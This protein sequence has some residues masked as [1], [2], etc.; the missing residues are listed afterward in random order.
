MDNREALAPAPD[1]AY[2][3]ACRGLSLDP[4]DAVS[5]FWKVPGDPFFPVTRSDHIWGVLLAFENSARMDCCH[6]C[7][8]GGLA[9]ARL[10][11]LC[12][13]LFMAASLPVERRSE[14]S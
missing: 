12:Y 9:V 4:N 10:L 2:C 13:F 7:G 3:S 8:S 6:A 14:M 11:F 5:Q 1:P